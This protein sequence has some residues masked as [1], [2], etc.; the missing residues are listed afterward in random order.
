M[1]FLASQNVSFDNRVEYTAR[2]DEI[3]RPGLS[4]FFPACQHHIC[5]KGLHRPPQWED[6]FRVDNVNTF[7]RW[8]QRFYRSLL[9]TWFKW[10][11]GHSIPTP[12]KLTSN[13][14]Q[15]RF[16]FKFKLL[17]AFHPITFVLISS[18]MIEQFINAHLFSLLR[19]CS[20]NKHRLRY[21][22]GR[23]HIFCRPHTKAAPKILNSKCQ[24]KN[25]FKGK[26]YFI[27]L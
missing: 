7:F 2:L 13:Q 18:P 3:L 21:F 20:G 25:R 24:Y 16:K 8:R 11:R 15:T 9:T 5:G 4:F 12:L 1:Y 14:I 23:P 10:K 27:C 17:S 6:H 19:N 26:T 22:C